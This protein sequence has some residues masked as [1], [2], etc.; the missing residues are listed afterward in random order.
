[1][2]NITS[3]R[4]GVLVNKTS[5][6]APLV[7]E[8]PEPSQ[9]SWRSCMTLTFLSD[10]RDIWTVCMFCFLEIFGQRVWFFFGDI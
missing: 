3:L 10:F 5:L 8:V 1:M 9:K 2:K 4:E 6:I 7:I